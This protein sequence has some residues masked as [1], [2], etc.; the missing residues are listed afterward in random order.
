MLKKMSKKMEKEFCDRM[1]ARLHEYEEIIKD[2]RRGLKCCPICR[3]FP[4]SPTGSTDCGFCPLSDE[5]ET[6]SCVG[7]LHIPG[8]PCIQGH[9]MA[10]S[11]QKKYAQARY[12]WLI[13]KLDKAGFEYK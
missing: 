3:T 8:Q 13:E 11:I 2:P 9:V 7:E 4:I 1:T 10:E 6:A 12:E 5:G